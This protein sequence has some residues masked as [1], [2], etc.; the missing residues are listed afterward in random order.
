MVMRDF[1]SNIIEIMQCS[2]TLTT[3][4]SLTSHVLLYL[5]KSLLASLFPRYI[6]TKICK[7]WA[8]AFGPLLTRGDNYGIAHCRRYSF[9]TEMSV[10]RPHFVF[11]P[12]GAQ[13][14]EGGPRGICMRA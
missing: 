8:V 13:V 7:L 5:S 3:C 2:T 9:G 12:V 14:F 11:G 10:R 6:C 1:L 4:D